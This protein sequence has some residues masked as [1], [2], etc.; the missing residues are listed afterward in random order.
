MIVER[1]QC[2]ERD[3]SKSDYEKLYNIATD[4][5]IKAD[6]KY[7]EDTYALMDQIRNEY[8]NCGVLR[9]DLYKQYLERIY[10]TTPEEYRVFYR[11][12]NNIENKEN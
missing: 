5:I 2:T 10:E 4:N 12:M 3:F 1:Y 7:W 8:V 9:E 11:D 6:E